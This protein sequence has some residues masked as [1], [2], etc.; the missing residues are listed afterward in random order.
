MRRFTALTAASAC[1]AALTWGAAT[2]QA[3]PSTLTWNFTD[4]TGP[5]G[6]PTSFSAWRTSQSVGNSLHLVDGSGTFVVLIAYNEDLGRY[7][8][9]VLPP[10]KTSAALVQCSTI[11]PAL[12][13]R[14]TV[15]GLFAP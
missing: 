2:A 11:G 10:G 12:G 1:A 6:T 14:F 15:W 7:N 5:A 9:P 4:C 13:F 8:I 3:D